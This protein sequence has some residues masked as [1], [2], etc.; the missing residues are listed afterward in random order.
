[1]PMRPQKSAPSAAPG[2]TLIELAVTLAVTVILLLGVLA[3]FDFNG[4]LTRV[5]THVADM[6]QSLRV[7]QDEMI[8]FLRMAGRGGLPVAN[9]ASSPLPN[10]VAVSVGDNTAAN[11]NV[12]AA[13]DSTRILAGTDVLSVRGIFS[14][15]LYQI[16]YTDPATLT[17]TP[18]ATNPTGGTLTISNLSPRGV[19]QDLTPLQTAI[20]GAGV[21]EALLLVSP[22]DDLVYAVVELVPAA[23]TSTANQVTLQ[24]RIT[25]SAL[26][27]AYRA[28]SPGGVFP[29]ALRSVAYAGILEQ[30]TYYVR[31]E[32]AI[33]TDPTSDLSPKLSRARL[34]PGTRQPYLGDASNAKV[35]V[36]DNIVDLQVALGFDSLNGGS[37]TAKTSSVILESADG[38][39]DDWLFNAV[40][41]NA[42]DAAWQTT[43][44]PPLYYVRLSTIA[45]TDRRDPQYLAPLLTRIEDH[46]YTASTG[47][48][49]MA[50]RRYRRRLLQTVIELRNLT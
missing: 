40:A 44:P 24:F 21:P 12:V 43:P 34:Y 31:E 28:L 33:A 6:Q 26:A 3:V 4:R 10:G 46:L 38:T 23:S 17:L 9:P 15:P 16:N 1:M 13:D 19:P 18:D 8:R 11:Q 42:A 5:Q 41:D 49:S 37:I 48:N 47:Q 45:R 32:H 14:T 50:E 2:F 27:T 25:G 35:D 20:A 36:A 7:G 22:L 29:A 30:Y 39:A